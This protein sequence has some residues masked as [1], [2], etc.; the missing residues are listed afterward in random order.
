V[1]HAAAVDTVDAAAV[2]VL[3]DDEALDA[4]CPASFSGGCIIE[5][6]VESCWRPPASGA[7]PPGIAAET[8]TRYGRP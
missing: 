4:A 2:R 3:E 6:S 8:G 1:S 7:T 5:M